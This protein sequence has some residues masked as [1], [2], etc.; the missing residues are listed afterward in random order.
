MALRRGKNITHNGKTGLWTRAVFP[1]KTA[2]RATLGP[3][4]RAGLVGWW[5]ARKTHRGV[6]IY[7]LD[8]SGVSAAAPAEG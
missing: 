4:F 1:S 7:M 2:A 6:R 8:L 5:M 3:L